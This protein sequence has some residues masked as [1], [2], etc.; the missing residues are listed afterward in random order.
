MGVKTIKK[1]RPKTI[2]VLSLFVIMITIVN[3]T[4]AVLTISQWQFLVSVLLYPPYYQ[5]LTG[6]FWGFF[7]ILLFCSLWFG[8][9]KSPFLMAIGTISYS[10]YIWFDRFI[11]S[12]APFDRNWLFVL[13]INGLCVIYI[14][15]SFRL[16][17]IKAYFGAAYDN[18]S[19]N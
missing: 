3:L 16:K 6:L 14:A 13:I 8:W 1:K 5:L 11:F 2:T 7:G 10:I 17:N 18:R 15:W 12:V 9:Q 19:Q 4:R